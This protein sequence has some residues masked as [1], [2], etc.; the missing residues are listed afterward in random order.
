VDVVFM[1]PELY[2]KGF[3]TRVTVPALD[4]GLCSI[5]RPHFFTG[6]A[7]VVHRL[8]LITKCHTAAFG[9]KDYQQLA[10]IRRMV[11]D[12][13]V[14]VDMIGVPIERAEDGVALSSRNKYLSDA[15]RVR[16]R[17]LS[18]SLRAMQASVAAGQRDVAALLAE[19]EAQLQ[20]DDL[21]YLQIVDRHSLEPLTHV[22][23]PA[24][25]AIAAVV[26]Q[27][28]LIDNMALTPPDGS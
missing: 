12:L 7:T 5:S 25:V 11:D 27:T 26:G 21:D 23:G 24:R 16:A 6:V 17:T 9:E 20:V 10:I 13:Q 14:A 18:A 1:P 22:H 8:L 19:A 4:K 2:P 28:R 15:D 3:E